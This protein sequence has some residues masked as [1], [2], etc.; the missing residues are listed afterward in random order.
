MPVTKKQRKEK[1][2]IVNLKSRVRT[3]VSQ[4]RIT[5]AEEIADHNK[6][7]VEEAVKCSWDEGASLLPK[8]TAAVDETKSGSAEANQTVTV[9]A[10][11]KSPTLVNG[12]PTESEADI[13]YFCRNPALVVIKLSDGRD[14]SMIKGRIN[15]KVGSKLRV[16]LDNAMG[17]PIYSAL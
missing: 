10:Q 13:F 16:K 8:L 12:W 14:V 15:W 5:E 6:F 3:L 9:L 2:R 4:G 1:Q 7:T 11:E 17:D